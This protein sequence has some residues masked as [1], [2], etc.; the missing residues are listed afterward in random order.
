M[1]K[2]K[3]TSETRIPTPVSV[4]WEDILMLP[5]FGEIDSKRIQEIMETVLAKIADT[6]SKI[7]ILDI[8]GVATIDSAVANHLLKIA[9]ATNLMGSQCIITG[10]S[11]AIAQ[12]LTNLGVGMEDV[13]T[14]AVLQDGLESAFDILGL[15]VRSRK[16]VPKRKAA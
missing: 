6:E 16:E 4:L 1:A 2:E 9:R 14:R 12:I 3:V 7:I 10:I 8:R 15:E 5:I 11:P 13:M